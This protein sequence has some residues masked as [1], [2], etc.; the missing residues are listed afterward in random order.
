MPRHSAPRP[1]ASWERQTLCSSVAEDTFGPDQSDSCQ[2]H[3]Y[4]I[5]ILGPDH[6]ALG[7]SS[8]YS[9]LAR[10]ARGGT[11]RAAVECPIKCRLTGSTFSSFPLEPTKGNEDSRAQHRR[12]G[13]VVAVASAS[14]GVATGAE[15]ALGDE[16]GSCPRFRTNN[17]HSSQTMEDGGQD[18]HLLQEP[19]LDTIFTG[20]DL[21]RGGQQIPARWV[22]HCC[23]HCGA[24]HRSPPGCFG[25]AWNWPSTQAKPAPAFAMTLSSRWSPS[26]A[27]PNLSILACADTV[28]STKN[29]NDWL[30]WTFPSTHTSISP[31]CIGV[32]TRLPHGS[33]PA[34]NCDTATNNCRATLVSLSQHPILASLPRG[35]TPIAASEP[36]YTN[37]LRLWRPQMA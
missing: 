3:R 12:S 36:T 4:E 31:K 11:G 33:R 19:S 22:R 25:G 21:Q 2:G 7:F 23:V 28:P 16:D 10:S 1:K 30:R 5:D 32:T 26:V 37:S 17:S 14:P 8:I 9:W 6:V 20:A 27:S 18:T 34:I 15:R 24:P 35:R 13:L 29:S